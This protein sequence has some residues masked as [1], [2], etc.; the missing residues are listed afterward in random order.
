MHQTKTK[1][2]ANFT[3]SQREDLDCEKNI[4]I[5]GDFYCPLN[6]KLDKKGGVIDNIECLQN[7][8]DLVDTWRVQN[9]QSRRYTWS[10]KA[11]PFFCRL[12][13]WLISNNLQ[14][15]VSS[16]DIIPAL[17]TDHAAIKLV[18]SEANQNAKELGF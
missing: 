6:P 3:R 5:R 2:L 12:D 1:L 4:V 17:K 8:L 7:E 18:F 10:Q 15:F 11:P 16:T 13:Y 14:Y 9:P